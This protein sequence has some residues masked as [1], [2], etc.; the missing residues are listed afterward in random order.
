[1]LVNTI[2]VAMSGRQGSDLQSH[3]DDTYD[4]DQTPT[5]RCLDGVLRGVC[6]VAQLAPSGAD[7]NVPGG[8]RL[9]GG[10][11]R[12]AL[13]NALQAVMCRHDAL[14]TRFLTRSD[15]SVLQASLEPMIFLTNIASLY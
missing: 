3:G 9:R 14:R 6:V 11:D 10:V 15:G 8:L 5:S 1:M 2:N 4:I 7:A 12:A 13:Q